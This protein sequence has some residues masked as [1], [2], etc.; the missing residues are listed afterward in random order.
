VNPDL[1]MRPEGTKLWSSFFT[2]RATLVKEGERLF[3]DT[4]L[5]TNGNSCETCHTGNN[6]F[7]ESFA[8]PYP[9]KVGMAHDRAGVGQVAADEFV[10]F[11]MVVPLAADPLPWESR[12][13][14]ALT[15]YVVDV[16]QKDFMA[17]MSNPCA[18]KKA[19]SNPCNPCAAKV[20]NP[21]NPCNPCAK[22]QWN[23]CNPC[24]KKM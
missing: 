9:H 5:S 6:M 23:P 18:M 2:S 11:C 13:L 15:A 4:S 16:K 10:Q 19:A 12:E 1:V 8:K 20:K 7:M 3:K 14:A 24:A 17:A 21:C 22:K